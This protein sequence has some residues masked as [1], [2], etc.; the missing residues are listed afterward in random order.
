[1]LGLSVSACRTI[2][3]CSPRPVWISS[4]DNPLTA[5]MNEMRNI[6]S[7]PS[8]MLPIAAEALSGSPFLIVVVALPLR[9]A[10]PDMRCFSRHFGPGPRI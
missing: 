10:H 3:P 5:E 4:T 7:H 6:K 8:I 2:P 9:N 1:M